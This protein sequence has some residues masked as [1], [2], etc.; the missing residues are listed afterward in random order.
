MVMSRQCCVGSFGR[1]LAQFIEVRLESF[2]HV[3]RCIF[4]ARVEQ[5]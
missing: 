1:P 5:P 2:Y 4:H 3:V